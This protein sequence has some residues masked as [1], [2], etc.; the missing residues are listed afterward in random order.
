MQ[1]LID[2]DVLRYEVGAVGE[3]KDETGEKVYRD[4]DFVR[5][6]FDGK[7]R[8][9]CEAVQATQPPILYLTGDALLNARIN[10]RRAR[11][12]LDPIE[13]LPNFRTAIAEGKAYKGTRKGEK[14]FHYHNLTSYILSEY[15][16]VVSNGCEA[17][18]LICI[19]QFKRLDQKDTI[20]CTRDKDLRMCPGLH[21][22]WECGKQPEFGPVEYDMLGSIELVETKS[23][24]KITGGGFAFFASQLLTGDVVDNIGGLKR[25]GPVAAWKTLGECNSIEGYLNAVRGAY[26][27]KLGEGWEVVLAEQ[28]NLLWMVRERLEDGSLKLFDMKE[29][30][31]GELPAVQ[32]EEV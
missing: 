32:N 18:D 17:D 5:E 12:G 19:E 31:N 27:G 25:W 28:C 7:I 20:I 23:G 3:Y 14:P 30:V 4:F 29:Y 2:A 9:I 26:S 10:K 11:E 21:Y 6:T 8:D 16:T 22:G 15:T 24:K 1:P 13:F